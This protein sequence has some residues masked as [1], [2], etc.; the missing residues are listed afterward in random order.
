[1][2]RDDTLST[3]PARGFST[4]MSSVWYKRA[5]DNLALP[6]ARAAATGGSS[7]GSRLL[8]LVDVD[9]AEVALEARVVG[10]LI[11]VETLRVDRV[12]DILPLLLLG[13]APLLRN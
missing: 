4:G 9:R 13:S 1:M 8:E 2:T 3:A 5:W 7:L 12:N 11:L 10:I 6:V